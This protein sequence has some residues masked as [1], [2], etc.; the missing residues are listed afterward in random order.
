M[1]RELQ[2][3]LENERLFRDW[4]RS[5]I[6][7]QKKKGADAAAQKIKRLKNNKICGS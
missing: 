6:L 1:L 2:L 7:K 5:G 4:L 3:I